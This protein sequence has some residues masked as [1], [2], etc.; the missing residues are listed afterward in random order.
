MLTACLANGERR[1]EKWKL[2]A[3]FNNRRDIAQ[4]RR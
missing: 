3:Y 2:F 4:S 1:L